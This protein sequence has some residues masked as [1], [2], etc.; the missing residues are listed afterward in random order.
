MNEHIKI[1]LP[2]PT[3]CRYYEM[4]IAGMV[5]QEIIIDHVAYRIIFAAPVDKLG[6]PEDGA[7]GMELRAK[8]V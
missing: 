8:V 3:N 4:Q 6:E 1:V 5:G 7:N 2:A